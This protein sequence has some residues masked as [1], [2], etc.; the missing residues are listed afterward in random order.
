MSTIWPKIEN[1]MEIWCNLN[2]IL[3][4]VG[5]LVHFLVFEELLVS[6]EMKILGIIILYDKL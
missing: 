3:T 4:K 1:L 6:A 5:V 2:E